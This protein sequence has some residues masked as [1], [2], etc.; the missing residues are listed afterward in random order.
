MFQFQTR[1]QGSAVKTVILGSD[2][3]TL[4]SLVYTLT[5]FIRCTKVQNRIFESSQSQPEDTTSQLLNGAFTQR[6]C[7]ENKMQEIFQTREADVRCKSH[8]ILENA[9][10]LHPNGTL[11]SNGALSNAIKVKELSA[12]A[13]S[14]AISTHEASLKAIKKRDE[15]PNS[16]TTNE[17][18][19]RAFLSG[20]SL[21]QSILRRKSS[22]KGLTRTASNVFRSDFSDDSTQSDDCENEESPET[23][24]LHISLI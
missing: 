11:T 21:S 7:H 6:K 18:L 23:V 14:D 8:T 15:L 13:F 10:S 20:K 4:K 2:D 22:R 24:S 3:E 16:F 19:Q 1:H 17:A 12:D 5:Y 9:R